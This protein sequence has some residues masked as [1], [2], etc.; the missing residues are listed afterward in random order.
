MMTSCAGRCA[1]GSQ[2]EGMGP[3]VPDNTWEPSSTGQGSPHP[4]DRSS[5]R[6]RPRRYGGHP[7][8]PPSK[9]YPCGL[10]GT[11]RGWGRGP[12]NLDL[13][14][15]QLAQPVGVPTLGVLVLSPLSPL[16]GPWVCAV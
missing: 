12:S 4:V 13:H 15:C 2:L 3:L 9:Y 10:C 7:P 5:L 6:Q 1:A 16:E 14:S 8:G 11:S